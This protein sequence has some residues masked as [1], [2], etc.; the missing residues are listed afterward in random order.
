MSKTARKLSKKANADLEAC[1]R[2]A[3]KM[4]DDNRLQEAK[5]L[6]EK[7]LASYGESKDILNLMGV[8]YYRGG[9]PN[10]AI[11]YFKR[12]LDDDPTNTEALWNLANLLMNMGYRPQALEMYES[13]LTHDPEHF[14]TLW[15]LNR[16]Y[17]QNKNWVGVFETGRKILRKQPWLVDVWHNIKTAIPYVPGQ[18]FSDEFLLELEEM[19]RYPSN[20]PS[21]VV[22][23][24]ALSMC[25]KYNE[26]DLYIARINKGETIEDISIK[27]ILRVTNFSLF[28]VLFRNYVVP[29]TSIEKFL[30]VIRQKLLCL[31]ESELTNCYSILLTLASHS[32][33]NEF[34]FFQSEYEKEEIEKLRAELESSDLS[35]D[36][37][38]IPKLLLFASYYP[39]FKLNHADKILALA[40][41]NNEEAFSRFVASTVGDLLEEKLIIK[42]IPN[43]NSIDDGVSKAVQEQ[44]EENPYPR[45]IDYGNFPSDSMENVIRLLFPWFDM[46]NIELSNSPE[47]LI[48]G[49]GTGKHAVGVARRFANSTV[50]A[51]DLSRASLAYAIR[52]SREY[53][54]DNIQYY[55]ADILKL[56]ALNRTFDIV[57]SA[58]VLHHMRDPMEGWRVITDL[59]KPGG[60]MKIGLYSAKARES[61]TA[62]RQEIKQKGYGDSPDEIRRFRHEILQ[63]PDARSIYNFVNSIDFYS[64]SECRDLLFHRQEHCTS[65]PE[66]RSSVNKLGLKFIGL[67]IGNASMIHEYV[68]YFPNDQN[69]QNLD[70]WDNLEQKMKDIFFGMYQFWCYKP[71]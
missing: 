52:K 10:A 23:V 67:E 29:H 5:T 70:N 22:A 25:R 48:A 61:I 56:A 71:L 35:S 64:M 32:F 16:M 54:F 45:W 50:L 38:V 43:L 53:G 63:N 20:N 55:Q 33:V 1:F 47:I 28:H 68:K 21:F 3:K 36:T 49:C 6:C 17:F 65:I 42:T 69:F 19:L 58:G 62:M 40:K 51:V 27:D 14:D 30:T 12:L 66:I 11:A 4:V 13:I 7:V 18:Y 44:Y 9:D 26:L 37:N 59:L 57:E 46:T 24:S 31:N 60:I 39:L 34:V 8:I 15:Q 41:K 2:E